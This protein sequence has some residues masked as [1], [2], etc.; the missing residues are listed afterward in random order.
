LTESR[1]EA[2][3]LGDPHVDCEHF[4]LAMANAATG[5]RAEAGDILLSFGIS[6]EVVEDLIRELREQEY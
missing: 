3:Y 1:E 5:K 6:S 2:K 4:L